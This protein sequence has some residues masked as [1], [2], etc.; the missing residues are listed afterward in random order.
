MG[1]KMGVGERT[2]GPAPNELMPPSWGKV[3]AGSCWRPVC[4]ETGRRISRIFTY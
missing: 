2:V 3:G 4:E 1:R